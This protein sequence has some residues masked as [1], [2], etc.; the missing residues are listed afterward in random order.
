[1]STTYNG[2]TNYATWRV[3]LEICDDY[4]SSR[5]NDI[6]DEIERGS[7]PDK[8]DNVS[9][10]AD[11]LSEIVDEALTNYGELTDGIA[12]DYARSFVNDVNF[13][14]IAQHAVDELT[15]RLAYEAQRSA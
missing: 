4:I 2:W 13:Y 1:M 8:F 6:I 3:N 15:E 11:E 14:E 7:S 10:W 12:L 9:T 5:L